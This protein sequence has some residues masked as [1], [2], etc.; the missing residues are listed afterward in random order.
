[1][2]DITVRVSYLELT[3][4]PTL[5]PT[6]LGAERISR[7]K[8]SV[9]EYLDLYGRVG[10]SFRWDQRFTMPRSELTSLLRSE[11]SQ[12]HLLEDDH[13]R[14]MGFC[15]FERS[16]PDIELKNFGLLPD[17]RGR[18]LG[19]WLLRTALHDEWKLQPA[20]IWL[21]TDDWDHPAALHL[22]G[23]AGFRIYMV[24]EEPAAY[25]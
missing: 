21:H 7:E 17:A 3:Q 9:D 13:G 18:G 14:A 15:E 25:L 10:R 2:N 19:S 23:S 11:R 20:R 1:M 8:L 5:I 16:L 4:T 22:Y 12:I 24:R 6:H